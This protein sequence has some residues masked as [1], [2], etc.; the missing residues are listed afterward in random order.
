MTQERKGGME[1]E[2]DMETG[3]HCQGQVSEVPKAPALIQKDM[4]E[5]C[6]MAAPDLRRRVE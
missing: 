5:T 3:E 1:E 4:A 6:F 2:T